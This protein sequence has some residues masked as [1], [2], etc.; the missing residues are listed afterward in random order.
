[1]QYVDVF[2]KHSN[3]H[4]SVSASIR[5]IFVDCCSPES[6]TFKTVDL[7]LVPSKPAACRWLPGAQRKHWYESMNHGLVCLCWAAYLFTYVGP[8]V[9]FSLYSAL[10]QKNVTHHELIIWVVM[11]REF[12]STFASHLNQ[13]QLRFNLE[14]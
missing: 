2:L 14:L 1:M 12:V 3:R 8:M 4:G 10:E 6:T 7:G 11:F 9:V 13:H 5:I